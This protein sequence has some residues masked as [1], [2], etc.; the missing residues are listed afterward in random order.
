MKLS[1]VLERALR[2]TQARTK[3]DLGEGDL[4]DISPVCDCSGF[5]SHA[6]G[7]HRD[8]ARSKG[9][10]KLW[11]ESTNIYNDARGRQSEWI[12][13]EKPIP[14]CTIA[15]PDI[16]RIQ[17]HVAIFEKKVG[18]IVYGIDCGKKGIT[19]RRLTWMWAWP[20]KPIY[21]YPRGIEP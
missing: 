19:R 1:D 6:N 4:N 18:P 14:G 21:C 3:Y 12:R 13:L 16:G 8:P 15:R 2:A 7:I 10:R 11:V 20:K 5:V 17:G 9:K